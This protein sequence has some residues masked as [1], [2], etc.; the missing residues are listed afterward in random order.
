MAGDDWEEIAMYARTFRVA[1]HRPRRGRQLSHQLLQITA[2]TVGLFLVGAWASELLWALLAASLVLTLG[3][4]AW[5]ARPFIGGCHP[6]HEVSPSAVGG[7]TDF[8]YL[9]TGDGDRGCGATCRVAY[10]D[11]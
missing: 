10:R 8:G 3:D 2:A 7:V 5:G 1:Q 11:N 6:L 9:C 4:P